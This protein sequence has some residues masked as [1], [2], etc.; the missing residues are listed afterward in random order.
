MIVNR[1]L[2][3]T[4]GVIPAKK[5]VSSLPLNSL[6]KPQ[7]TDNNF[8]G[9]HYPVDVV[10]LSNSM[11]GSFTSTWVL[12]QSRSPEPSGTVVTLIQE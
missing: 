12:A 1:S 3:H 10:F 8:A 7:S 5:K 9:V 4:D 2:K 11:E 6:F